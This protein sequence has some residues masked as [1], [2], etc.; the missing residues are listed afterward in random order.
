M[1]HVLQ[2]ACCNYV[3]LLGASLAAIAF[4]L[5]AFVWLLGVVLGAIGSIGQPL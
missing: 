3:V 4:G 5:P 2:A 1:K